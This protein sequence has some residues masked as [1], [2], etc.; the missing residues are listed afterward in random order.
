MRSLRLFSKEAHS[1]LIEASTMR[2]CLIRRGALETLPPSPLGGYLASIRREDRERF[3]E[4]M[5]GTGARWI[6]ETR[7]LSGFSMMEPG[8]T[9]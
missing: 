6:G 4:T 2:G 3:E 7:V 5:H 8:N 1:A 9:P